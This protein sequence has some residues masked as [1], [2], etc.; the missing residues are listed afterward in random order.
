MFFI[1][2]IFAII[3]LILGILG[4]AALGF[5]VLNYSEFIGIAIAGAVIA[6]FVRR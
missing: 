3:G 2:P 5:T 1:S 4:G 6:W